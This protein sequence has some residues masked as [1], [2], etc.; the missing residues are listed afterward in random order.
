MGDPS[1][2]AN[3]ERLPGPEHAV[4]LLERLAVE[5]RPLVATPETGEAEGLTSPRPEPG[6]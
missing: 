5:Q 6:T 4:G 1:Y 2:R 3:A